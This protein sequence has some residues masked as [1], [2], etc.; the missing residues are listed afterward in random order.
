VLKDA[1]RYKWLR[2]SLYCGDVDV[3]EAYLTMKAVGSCPSEEQFDAAIDA[4]IAAQ[5]GAV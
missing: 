3:G 5:K 1:E 2:D 4:A